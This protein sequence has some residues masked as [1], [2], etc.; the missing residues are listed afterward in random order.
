[1]PRKKKVMLPPHVPSTNDMM[2]DI[3]QMP[4]RAKK[5]LGRNAR[6]ERLLQYLIN[7]NYPE[8]EECHVPSLKVIATDLDIKYDHVRKEIAMIYHDLNLNFEQPSIP[9]EFNQILYEFTLKG[10]RN[11]IGIQVTHLPVLP[12]VGENIEFPFFKAYLDTRSFYVESIHHEFR[13]NKQIICI[14]LKDGYYN[15]YWHIRKDKAWEENEIPFHEM[16]HMDD[17]ELKRRLKVGSHL[18]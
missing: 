3:V 17:W 16:I 6:Y 8:T 5:L 10:Y 13:D 11:A 14:G 4:S 12:R 2:Y 7:L 18:Y 9:F 15:L 1:M